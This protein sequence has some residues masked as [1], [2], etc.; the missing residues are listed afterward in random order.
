MNGALLVAYQDVVYLVAVVVEGI[1][2]GDYGTAG[3]TKDCLHTL[4]KE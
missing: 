2:H 1:I 3:I 4:L